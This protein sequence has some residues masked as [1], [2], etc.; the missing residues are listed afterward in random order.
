MKGVFSWRCPERLHVASEM[1]DA[2]KPIVLAALA[3]E[4]VQ[5]EM[6]KC[7]DIS[8]LIAKPEVQR[9]LLESIDIR[10]LFD[11]DQ[12]KDQLA[13]SQSALAEERFGCQAGV[14]MAVAA[15]AATPVAASRMD[16]A[17]RAA[18][19]VGRRRARRAS[20]HTPR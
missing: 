5:K 16:A 3:D 7:L 9:Q 4:A 14:A 15:G 18:W 17:A 13:A 10:Q 2:V 12:M 1:E 20:A 6:S 11:D 19:A 8:A